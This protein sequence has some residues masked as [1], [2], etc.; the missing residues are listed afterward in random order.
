MF[1]SDAMPQLKTSESIILSFGSSLT[2]LANISLVRS[3][4]SAYYLMDGIDVRW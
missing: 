3:L 1:H 4:K 2:L